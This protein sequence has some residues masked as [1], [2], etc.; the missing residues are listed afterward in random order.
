M[1]NQYFSLS[2]KL[3]NFFFNQK[4][5]VKGGDL[6]SLPQGHNYQEI[7]FERVAL[8]KLLSEMWIYIPP[9]SLLR[10]KGG[11][12]TACTVGLAP[13][14]GSRGGA[15]QQGEQLS[16]VGDE[17]EASPRSEER[18]GIGSEDRKWM[19]R[20]PRLPVGTLASLSW[21]ITGDDS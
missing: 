9:N 13:G 6:T 11:P 14:W 4:T 20:G 1:I 15:G 16:P 3:I 5:E 10:L 8:Y 21:C 18:Q 19:R 7:L 17:A 12:V 2:L